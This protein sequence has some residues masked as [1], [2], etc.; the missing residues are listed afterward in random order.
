VTARPEDL[1]AAAGE[2][3]AS[4]LLDIVARLAA[5]LHPRR[6]K[7]AVTLDSRL[8]RELGFDSL[9]RVEL[10]AREGHGVLHHLVV[11]APDTRG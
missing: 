1:P 11:Q 2:R 8:D 4:E 6:T 5:E 10:I 7:P 9:G 3:S